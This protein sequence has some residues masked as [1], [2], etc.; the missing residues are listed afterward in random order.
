MIIYIDIDIDINI[1]IYIYRYIYIYIYQTWRCPKS[2]GYPQLSS[3]V[4]RISQ[5]NPGNKPSLRPALPRCRSTR[6][7]LPGC[8]WKRPIVLQIIVSQWE[9]PCFYAPTQVS[10]SVL[11]SSFSEMPWTS[12]RWAS[13]GPFQIV[14]FS[15]YW[16]SHFAQIIGVFP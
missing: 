5:P 9:S 2:W 7:R 10:Y 15:I 1:S 12:A 3:N 11:P 4:H 16:E 6:A 14:P 8:E 13:C